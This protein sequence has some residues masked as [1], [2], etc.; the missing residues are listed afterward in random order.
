VHL[1]VTKHI[2]QIVAILVACA[3]FLGAYAAEPVPS[4]VSVATPRA[5]ELPPGQREQTG[6]AVETPSSDGSDPTGIA[7]RRAEILLRSAR[8]AVALGDIPEAVARFDKLLRLTPGDQQARFEYAGLLLRLGR[9]SDGRQQLERLV[10]EQPNTGTYRL[11]LADLLLRLKD[12]QGAREQLSR[13]LPDKLLGQRAAIKIVQSLM[14][15]HRLAEAQQF[16]EQHVA[17][18]QNLDSETELALAQLLI[19]IQRPAD[20]VR[21][22]M[23]MHEAHRA[24][25]KISAALVLALVR[26][27]SR[28]SALHLIDQWED[29]PNKDFGTWLDLAT[30]LYQEQAFPEALAVYRQIWRRHPGLQR[31]AL[32]VARTHLRLYEVD[33]ARQILDQCHGHAEGREFSA[34]VA[35]YHTLV[36][37]YA[38]AIAIAKQRLRADGGDVQAAILLGD[39]YHASHQFAAADA[40]YA[41]A[42]AICSD[43]D[44]DLAREIRRLQAKNYLLSRRFDQALSVLNA[45]L[46]ERPTD[47]ASRILLIETLT[48]KKCFDAAAAIAREPLE[49]EGPRDRSALR[50]QLGY[51]LLKQGSWP[52]AAAEFRSLASEVDGT[53]PDVAY[54][55]YRAGTLLVQ[56]ELAQEAFRLGP[57]PLAPAAT[58]G[59]VFG[60]RAMAYCDCQSA[61]AVLDETL[62]HA[63]ANIVLL[64]MRGQAAQLCDGSCGCDGCQPTALG[65]F[66]SVLRLSPTNIP[67]RL[68]CARVLNKQTA[69]DGA[70][71][72]YLALLE[73]MPNDVNLTREAGRMV[74]GW[75]GLDR[76]SAFYAARQTVVSQE[77]QAD[78]GPGESEKEKVVNKLTA[79]GVAE[80]EPMLYGPLLSSE[81]QARN[82]QGWRLYDAIS[83]YERLIE[84]EPSNDSAMFDLAQAQSSLNRTQC[85]IEAYQR[86]LE[87]NPCHQDAS[88][89]LLRNQL[90]MQPKILAVVDYEVQFGRQGVANMTWLN[91]SLSTR[92]P[93]GDENEFFEW[94]YRE[95]LLQPTDDVADFGEIPF[96]RWQQKYSSDR[97]MFAEV[98]VEKYQYGLTTRPTFTAGLDLFKTDDS[99]V[100]FSSFL[101]NYYVCGEAIRQDIYTTGIQIDGIYRPRR[102]WTLSGYYRLANFSDNNW[103]N[104]VNLN[105]AQVLREGRKQIRGV[106]DCNYYAF[107]QQTVF[108]PI[109]GSLVGTIH[110]Y[111]SPAG[112][113]FTTVGLEWKH[114][115]SCDK[116]KG[117][118]EHYYMVFSGAAVDSN[119]V[120]FFVANGRWQRDV[121]ESLT[122][123]V[124]FNLIRSANQVYDAAGVIAYGVWRL[125]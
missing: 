124:D 16:Y 84:M 62:R 69:Y 73:L 88:V 71:A 48:E 78:S 121:S 12:Y 97:L 72:E 86:L 42:L 43:T 45:L 57:T 101:K 74:Q 8:N 93:L 21:M 110:P 76:A 34:V 125:W 15:D 25:D 39:A 36:G 89:A 122:W 38:E 119:G 18:L 19:D 13:L 96:F 79:A 27:N 83:A 56:A 80:S 103:V 109:P 117:A 33:L 14:W 92:R 104:W 118:N 100:R 102:L 31:A 20:A 28:S 29:Q 81:F 112:Y 40:A 70:Y 85:A 7:N 58:W 10:A 105:S 17:K 66:Q 94:G 123:T 4:S 22:L 108:G 1:E 114:W 65:W 82:L 59:A 11:A 106:I 107:A 113:T 23:P 67:A 75:K 53:T 26:M 49:A 35:E 90:E 52:E 95:R 3:P 32:G 61:A 41:S 30:R 55:L 51:V 6:P 111:W 50:T 87:V 68:G 91:L 54:G 115:L 24:D 63:P 5:E 37:E 64:N 9:F 98:A 77:D 116:F 120:G 47:V 99:E 2:A 44:D 60:G 46:Q